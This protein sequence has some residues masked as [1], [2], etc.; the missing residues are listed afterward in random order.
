MAKEELEQLVFAGSQVNWPLAAGHR[1][2]LRI[3]GDVAD[4]EDLVARD[5]P[6]KLGP[7][8]GKELGEVERLGDIVVGTEFQPADSVGDIAAGGEHD[9]RYVRLGPNDS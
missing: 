1:A 5:P 9:D 6:S 8:S 2:T 7:H 3:Q 4:A